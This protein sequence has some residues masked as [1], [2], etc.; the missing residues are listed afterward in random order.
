MKAHNPT[1]VTGG[2]AFPLVSHCILLCAWSPH[3]ILTVCK[4]LDGWEK[5]RSAYSH[6]EGLTIWEVQGLPKSTMYPG[7]TPSV[8]RTPGH[9][10]NPSCAGTGT[11]HQDPER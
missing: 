3:V 11:A 10:F 5:K 2:T 9:S 4:D 8:P 1:L 7:E 6:G